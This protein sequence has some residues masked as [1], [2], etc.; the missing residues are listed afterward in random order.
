MEQQTTTPEQSHEGDEL[1]HPQSRWAQNKF[2][3][4]IFASIFIAMILVSI[5]MSL[6]FNSGTAQLDLSRPDY[7]SV[8]DKIKPDDAFAGFPAS[9]PVDDATLGDFKKMYDKRAKEATSVDAFNSD[10]LS[11]QALGIDDPSVGDNQ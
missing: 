6:Y 11:D 9:G 2:L 10:V 1:A 5:S 7:K 8:R 4:I 3:I